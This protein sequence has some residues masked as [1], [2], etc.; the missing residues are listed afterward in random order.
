MVQDVVGTIFCNGGRFDFERKVRGT[1]QNYGEEVAKGYCHG[2]SLF[3]AEDVILLWI[4]RNY[5]NGC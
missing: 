5:N 4:P 1:A 2:A 3:R